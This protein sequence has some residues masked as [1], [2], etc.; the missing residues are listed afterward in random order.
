VLFGLIAELRARGIAVIYVSHRLDEIFAVADRVTVLRNGRVVTCRRVADISQG[1]LVGA[2]LGEVAE[3]LERNEVAQPQQTVG[4]GGSGAAEQPRTTA[5]RQDRSREEVVVVRSVSGD[6]LKDANITLAPG[7]VL[8]LAGL[9]GS[10]HD[11]LPYIL[12]GAR[13]GQSGTI[14]VGGVET[15]ASEVTPSKMAALGVGFVPEDR[16]AEGVIGRMTVGNNMTLPINGRFWSGGRFRSRQERAYA[17]RWCEQLAIHPRDDTAVVETLSGGNQQ[18][19]LLAKALAT[20][21]N[22]LVMA[23]PTSGVDVGARIGICAQVR[24]TAAAGGVVIVCS[25]D[26]MDLLEMCTR[27]LFLVSGEVTGEVSGAAITE[28]AIVTG[29]SGPSG[30]NRA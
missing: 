12:A 7:E 10:G 1:D 29:I 23:N 5:G 27:V 14:S 15:S 26:A 28:K 6:V 19:V 13:R 22:L 3:D 17:R 16:G 11:E 20:A 21:S 18:K 24:E 2:M 9:N 8:G 30:G 4:A 25:T